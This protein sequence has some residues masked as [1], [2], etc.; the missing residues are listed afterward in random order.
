MCHSYRGLCPRDLVAVILKVLEIGLLVLTYISAQEVRKGGHGTISEDTVYISKDTRSQWIYHLRF[1]SYVHEVPNRCSCPVGGYL[2]RG[3]SR[4]Q[5][6]FLW[7]HY[8]QQANSILSHLSFSSWWKG[9][10]HEVEIW[11]VLWEQKKEH[12]SLTEHSIL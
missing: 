2:L 1:I 3:A 9:K 6:C 7:S 10:D 4:I 5:A 8:C 12:R 11:E